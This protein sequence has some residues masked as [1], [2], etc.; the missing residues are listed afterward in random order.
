MSEDRLA[1]GRSMT[2]PFNW[3]RCQSDVNFPSLRCQYFALNHCGC[4]PP[5][6]RGQYFPLNLC[7]CRSPSLR[8]QYFAL[9]L[10]S[11]PKRKGDLGRRVSEKSGQYRTPAPQTLESTGTVVP[12]SPP[13]A[14]SSLVILRELKRKI[15]PRRWQWGSSLRSQP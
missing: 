3:V 4:S 14:F 8:G 9:R 12:A 1:P 13:V 7:A 6:L 15:E 5:S 2:N 10:P 11:S